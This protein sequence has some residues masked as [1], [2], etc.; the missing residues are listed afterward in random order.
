MCIRD[1]DAKIRYGGIEDPR[2]ISRVLGQ[3]AWDG[4]AGLFPEEVLARSMRAHVIPDPESPRTRYGVDVARSGVDST[5]V[6]E[7]QEGWVWET[8]PETDELIANTGVRGL[9]VRYIDSWT[10]VPV[11]SNDPDNPGTAERLD[12]LARENSVALVN[13]DAGGGLGVG[14]F[15]GIANLWRSQYPVQPTYDVYP[16]YGN[17]QNVDKRAFINLRAFMFSE[18]KRR[19]AAGELDLDPKDVDLFDELRGIRAKIINGSALQIESKEDMRKR[20]VK[21][22]DRADALWYAFYDSI[23]VSTGIAAGTVV[24]AEPEEF[25]GSDGFFHGAGGISSIGW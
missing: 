11:T 24:T 12:K 18:L 21:S 20:G 14:V 9:R 25:I 15:D 16:V 4:G 7:C 1:R 5:Q 3:W 10:K 22:P 2:Y 19:M 13:I 6:Y 8:D 17:D 23:T